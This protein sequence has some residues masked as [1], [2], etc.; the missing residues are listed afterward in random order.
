[1]AAQISE[2]IEFNDSPEANSG[3]LWEALKA[4]VRGQIISFTSYM[5]KAERTKRQ[6]ILDKLLKLDET[7]A[8]SLTCPLQKTTSTSIRI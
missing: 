4:F 1:M 3:F 6:D 2:Y 5:S 7:Y 8:V